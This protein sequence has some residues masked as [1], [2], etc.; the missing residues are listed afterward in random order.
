MILLMLNNINK[1]NM[2]QKMMPNKIISIYLQ[3]IYY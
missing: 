3:G 2:S 1:E